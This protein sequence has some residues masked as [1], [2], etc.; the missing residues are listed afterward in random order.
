MSPPESPSAFV[1]VGTTRFDPL[2][3]TAT[4]DRVLRALAEAGYKVSQGVSARC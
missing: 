1:T 2:V 3:R 4:R